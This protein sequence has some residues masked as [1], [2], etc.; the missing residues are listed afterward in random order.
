MIGH[1]LRLFHSPTIREVNCD[2]SGAEGMIANSS[3]KPSSDRTP[4]NHIPSVS[5]VEGFFRQLL[6]SPRSCA[7][8][9]RLRRFFQIGR[10]DVF[11]EIPFEIVMAGHLVLFAAFLSESNPPPPP[12]RIKIFDAH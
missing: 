3:L 11:M 9:G 7:E 4:P 10:L 12:L 2:A 5:S 1:L 8:K 6:F